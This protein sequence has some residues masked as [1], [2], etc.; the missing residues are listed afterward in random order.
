MLEPLILTQAQLDFLENAKSGGILLKGEF[1]TG[2]TT[3][4]ILRML[5]LEKRRHRRLS[6][7]LVLAPQ[8]PL[9]R[10][11]EL[12][13]IENRANQSQTALMTFS[14]LVKRNIALFWPLV[15]DQAR[16]AHPEI[17]PKFLTIETAQFYLSQ[18]VDPLMD[19][20]IFSGITIPRN[21]I[22]SQLLD[23]L[24]K[25][26][27]IPLD[28]RG[29]SARLKS[30]WT[31]GPEQLLAYEEVQVC[32]NAFRAKCLQE[33]LLDYSLQV[34]VFAKQLWPQNL[35]RK[36]MR[37][38]YS[39][40][41]YE[42]IEEEPPLIH[43]L[44]AD[45]QPSLNSVC[46]VMDTGGGYRKFL[47]AD[48][49]SALRFENSNYRVFTMTE[50][51]VSNPEIEDAKK[52]FLSAPHIAQ[53]PGIEIF[54]VFEQPSDL[55]IFVPELLDWTVEQIKRLIDQGTKPSEIAILSPF[56][57]STFAFYLQAKMQALGLPSKTA[58]ASALM[59][60]DPYVKLFLN[61]YCLNSNQP[62]LYV[63]QDDLVDLL[64]L[65]LGEINR[66]Q[67]KLLSNAICGKNLSIQA[68]PEL[69]VIE[70]LPLDR[71]NPESLTRYTQLRFWLQDFNPHAG[72]GSFV[73]RLF[74]ELLTQPGF[75]LH[76]NVEAGR[77]AGRMIESF[78]KFEQALEGDSLETQKAVYFIQSV[79]KGLLSGIYEED[80]Q[81]E[82]SILITPVLSFLM[83]N[84]A[85][86]YQFWMNTGS[87]GWHER[88]EQPLTQAYVLSRSWKSGRVWTTTDDTQLSKE[89]LTH[90]VQGLLAR[91]RKK[92]FLGIS[93]YDESGSQ[94]TGLL[95]Q[96]LQGLFRRAIGGETHA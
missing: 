88:L 28:Y 6:S 46:L 69:T 23:S 71:F 63:T 66:V 75:G 57:S 80:Q 84:Q 48:P 2:K 58:K 30:A 86:D 18:I 39:D 31:G 95:L 42:N 7:T 77:L 44:I 25:A 11:Y 52:L 32:L 91:C 54:K 82:D 68:L 83:R 79:R 96:V 3:A 72:F 47:G 62:T 37:S 17:E 10:P 61:C 1:G 16:F 85:V 43:D 29:I 78:I 59:R 5:K 12:A 67:A 24:N 14:S 22:Y 13:Q 90:T 9:L 21:R 35:F 15:A 81:D 34:E 38:S 27:I 41:I 36:Y 56:L 33:N 51:L 8:Y 87:N 19:K 65:S 49:D 26:A 60:D 93:V 76:D 4:S 70:E 40:L 53:K 64:A 20:G 50:S 92:V 55:P 73:S 94:E 74:G 45:L 89:T